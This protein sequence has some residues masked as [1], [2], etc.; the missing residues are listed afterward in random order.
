METKYYFVTYR[1]KKR[2]DGD[3]Y[4]QFSNTVISI[5]P[6]IWLKQCVENYQEIYV[7]DFYEEISKSL[8]NEIDGLL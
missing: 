5:H 1:W 4:W 2:T 8:F 6:V 3:L 7:I